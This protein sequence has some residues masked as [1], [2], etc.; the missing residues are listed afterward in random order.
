MPYRLGESILIQEGTT[1]HHELAPE[2]QYEIM[3]VAVTAE[4]KKILQTAIL[5][6]F[7]A[8]TRL[9]DLYLYLPESAQEETS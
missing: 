8:W 1:L 3:Q 2:S 7:P 5:V 6:S 4:V 9:R